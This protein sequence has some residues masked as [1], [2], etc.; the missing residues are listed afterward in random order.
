MVSEPA[1][2][3]LG[4]AAALI[5][6]RML[7]PVELTEALLARIAAL[8]PQLNAFVRIE[9]E[10]ALAE[11]RRAEAEAARGE[12]RGPLH[13]VPFGLKDIIDAAGLPTTAHSKLLMQSPPA[14]TDAFVAARLKA[15][16]GIL[17]GK[18]ATHEFAIGGPSFDLPWPPA[19]NPW[20][21][22]TMPGGSSSGSGAA[23]AAGLMAG[24]LGSDTGGSVRNPASS[25]AIVG[26]KPTYGR[27]SRRGV[28][29]LSFSLDHVGP[30][31]RGV[32]DNA[33]MLGVIA[34]H[35]P[36][37]PGSARVPVPDF[38]VGLDHGVRGCRIGVIRHFFERDIEAAPEMAAALEA[39]LQVLAGLGA[40]IVEIETRPLQEYAA[41]NRVILLSEAFAI[42]RKWLSERPEDYAVSTRE[43]LLPG[44]FFSAGD[45]VDA[46][47]ARR[48]IAAEFEVLIQP[49]DAVITASAMDTPLAIDDAEA[50][51]RAYSRQ[52]RAP[53][54]L[55]GSPALAMPAG[56]SS[57]GLPL[58]L[59]IVGKQF[60]EAGVY[61]VAA[62]YEAATPW[63]DMHPP[64]A[65]F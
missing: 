9:A 58:S 11:A 62:A 39:A 6:E 29:P 10:S 53:F 27:V 56:F 47:R 46:L 64:M 19:R 4:E 38:A 16:G 20:N 13:G 41:C 35:D 25:C 17:I 57:D 42:H 59:Q 8:E 32:A 23:V 33:L 45:Y 14:E 5:A 34:G 30:L 24:A 26:L 18:M 22:G 36:A 65:A 3:G 43:R 40:E 61:R 21:P 55:T 44:A 48:R 28:L 1:W 63:K 12:L 7:S 15:A 54:N 50:I 51:A 49:Y 37:D 60:D 52:A 2:L 31:T